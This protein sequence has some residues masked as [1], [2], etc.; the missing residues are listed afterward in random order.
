VIFESLEIVRAE[1]FAEG[2]ERPNVSGLVE[3][4]KANFTTEQINNIFSTLRSEEAEGFVLVPVSYTNPLVR[5]ACTCNPDS[6]QLCERCYHFEIGSCSSTSWGC[7]PFW[8]FQC[9]SKCRNL[10]GEESEDGPQGKA[11]P[12]KTGRVL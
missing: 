11:I 4:M 10:N 9:T 1:T 3:R 2:T 7:G 6:N 8:A 5:G 12:V